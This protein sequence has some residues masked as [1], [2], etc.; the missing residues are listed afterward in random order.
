MLYKT[1]YLSGGIN[2]NTSP[3]LIEDGES[4][5]IQNFTTTKIGVLKKTGDYE[6]KNAQI[7]SSKNMLGGFD[8]QRV[9]GT[10]EHIVAI[11]GASNAGIYKDVSGTWTTQS[12]SL[13]AGS[14]VRFAYSPALDTLFACNYSDATRSYDGSSWSTSTNVT[15]APKAKYI[16]NFGQRI[17]VLNFLV[18]ATS[19]ISRAYY[20]STVDSGS[21]TW[22]TT[23]DWD[24]FN[25]VITGVGK[26][27]E[28][29]FVGC[30]NS[31]WEYTFAG[32]KY[33]VS[34]HGC[35]SHDG[36]SEYGTWL[37][38]PSHDGMYL[39]DGSKEMKVSLAVQDYWDA[40]PNA[41]L[42]SIQAKIG[43]ASCRERV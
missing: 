10:H 11:D 12:Q 21:I 22:D 36:I 29:M 25:D 31:C 32:A 2:R 30:Q 24:T 4:S 17:Y 3:F 8:F 20:S 34:G 23:N 15:S 42:S 19:Y 9:D 33:Q 38:F 6:L 1:I 28:N 13:T 35:V 18:G 7:I 27:G 41:N 37:F 16:I 5:D 43:R 39:F 26:S 40:I 14:K